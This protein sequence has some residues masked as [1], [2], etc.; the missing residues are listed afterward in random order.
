MVDRRGGVKRFQVSSPDIGGGVLSVFMDMSPRRNSMRI[1]RM[2][3]VEDVSHWE[4]LQNSQA[5]PRLSPEENTIEGYARG[6]GETSEGGKDRVAR[7][8]RR[9]PG[10]RLPRDLMK[11][12]S[13][14][15]EPV[16]SGVK[17][18]R[19]IKYNADRKANIGYGNM[20]IH[21]A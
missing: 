12:V 18:H 11:G 13:R 1:G 7:A 6:G 4:C 19:T 10:E 15:G 8:M 5:D 3:L 17:S 21:L 2:Y 14:T 9:E 16:A 20:E